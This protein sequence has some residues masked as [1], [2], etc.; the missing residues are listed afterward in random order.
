MEYKVFNKFTMKDITNR[1]DWVVTPDGRL[2]VNE[3]GD[4]ITYPEGIYVLEK[5]VEKFLK[6]DVSKSH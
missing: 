4:F 6:G 5:D 2:Y 1:Y 3:W